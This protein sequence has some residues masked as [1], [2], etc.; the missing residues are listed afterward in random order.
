[1]DRRLTKFF[2][3]DFIFTFEVWNPKKKERLISVIKLRQPKELDKPEIIKVKRQD[4]PL[5]KTWNS[6]FV[7]IHYF[8]TTIIL[9]FTYKTRF[10]HLFTRK[11]KRIW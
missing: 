4:S 7:P 2:Y 5:M 3:K 6:N 9:K 1:M 10:F 8:F 11:I